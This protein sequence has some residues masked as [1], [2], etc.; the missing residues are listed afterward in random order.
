MKALVVAAYI[1]ACL[2]CPCLLRIGPLGIS[3]DALTVLNMIFA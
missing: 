3:K 1:S 2:G